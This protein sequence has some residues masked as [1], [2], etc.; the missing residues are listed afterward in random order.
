M[1]NPLRGSA[2]DL[3]PVLQ[4]AEDHFTTTD[5]RLGVA[6]ACT[7]LNLDLRGDAEAD[8]V[9]ARFAGVFAAL[10]QGRGARLQLVAVNRP[11]RA[12]DWLPGHLAQYR[13]P[14]QLAGFV[15]RLGPAYARELGGRAIPDLRFYAIATL[16]GPPAPRGRAARAFRR[17][18]TLA[19]DRAEYTGVVAEA[20]RLAQGLAEALGAVGVR[21]APLGRQG[22]IDLL[23]QCG[24][25]DWSRDAAAP[26]AEHPGDLRALRDRLAQSRLVRR[27]EWLRL[28]GGY[29][30]TLALRALPDL[31]FPG[32]L[33]ALMAT[34]V[35]FRFALHAEPLV[36]AKE[37]TTIARRLRQRH[38]IL[39]ADDD[40]RRAP[41]VEQEAAYDEDRELLR[42]LAGTGQRTFRTA[43]FVAVRARTPDALAA[44][45]G[46]V[47]RALGDAG[48]TAVD[49]C[50]LWQEPA[51]RATLPLGH[52]PAGLAYRTATSSLADSL[53]FLQHR[54]GTRGGVLIG[55]ADPGQ[56]VVALDL[57]DPELPNGT[58]I[59]CGKGGSGKTLFAQHVALHFVAT[60][61][62]VVVFDRSGVA[63]RAGHWDALA[64][65]AGGQLHRVGLDSGFRINPWALPPGAS[66]PTS[67]KLDYLVG[68]HRR[69]L[70]ELTD[71]EEALLEGGCRAVYRAARL[72]PAGS[73]GR[74]G[75]REV[76]ER[77]LVAWLREAAVAEAEP[78]RRATLA[79]LADRLAPFADD[80][81]YA[82]L[83][84]GPTSVRPDAPLEV[85]NFKGLADRVVPFAMLPLLEYVW[86][87]LGDPGRPCLLVMDE[88]WKLLEHPA[89]AGFVAEVARTGRHYG[90]AVL[91]LSQ[92][93]RDYEGPVGQ[94]ILQ[95]AALKL[96]LHQDA[97]ALADVQR[98]CNL[99][100]DALAQV[101]RADTV[102]G[103]SA[104]AYLHAD[105]GADA[106]ALRLYVPPEEYWLFTSWGPERELR[107]A[108]IAAHGGDVWAAV[109][110]LAAL[111]PAEREALRARAGGGAERG[112]PAA[113]AA[114]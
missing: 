17:R 82:P 28:D 30:A 93:I 19:R 9:A 68:L 53:P 104:G 63:G 79:A 11:I 59:V 61:G 72:S 52:N 113:L 5:G 81:T 110:A 85:F 37:R 25:P 57:Y 73:G 22:L 107:E 39:G 38:A 106:G 92:F 89:T 91:N 47:V 109:R 41:D 20:G 50:A 84:D 97:N 60:G 35:P 15:D 43:V 102:K 101:A 14:P 33:H 34:G 13:P 55:F 7:G 100:P 114:D 10:P 86:T 54:A 64:R 6:L 88:S 105:E 45:A 96:F 74:E 58:M 70:G 44:A 98:V 31:T 1:R 69:L 3:L 18:R 12:E 78:A 4:I 87:V 16:P 8:Q 108:A 40:A 26:R 112:N 32:W 94:A 71:R 67:G 66:A 46:Q 103:V 21:A 24:N 51:W 29:E 2:A 48:G 90:L 62:R 80:G 23:W 75:R 77:E 27:A 111:T 56:E 99:T 42:E 95:N 76:Y 65:A 83:L 49:R 36:K